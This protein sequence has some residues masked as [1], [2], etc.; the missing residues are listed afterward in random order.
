MRKVIERRELSDIRNRGV[1][2]DDLHCGLTT[3][4]SGINSNVILIRI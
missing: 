2:I 1:K 4:E 3:S